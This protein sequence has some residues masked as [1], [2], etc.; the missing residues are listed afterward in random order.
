M[1]KS[2]SIARIV[3]PSLIVMVTSELKVWNPTLYDEQII[4]L[5][6]L[7]GVLMFIAG[8]SIIHKHNFWVR[9][10]QTI[11]TIIGWF[12]LLLGTLRMFF[13]Q[14]YNSN[15]ENDNSALVVEIILILIGVFLTYKA[16]FTLKKDE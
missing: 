14:M 4:P 15:F 11:I 1:N 6:Y 13:P 12:G 16:Y 2:K 8:L 9:G 7:S 10:W 5:I 3:G